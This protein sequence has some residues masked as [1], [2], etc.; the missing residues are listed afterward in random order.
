M[1]NAGVLM[2]SDVG[3]LELGDSGNRFW[4]NL[5][6]RELYLYITT[7]YP[8]ILRWYCTKTGFISPV[9]IAPR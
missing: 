7:L 6:T 8:G 5:R 9:G 2:G 4:R 3:I 1:R